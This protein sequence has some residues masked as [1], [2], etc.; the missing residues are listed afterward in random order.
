MEWPDPDTRI[1]VEEAGRLGVQV[2]VSSQVLEIGER[3]RLDHPVLAVELFDGSQALGGDRDTGV[4]ADLRHGL[5][6]HLGVARAHAHVGHGQAP[7]SGSCERADVVAP[8]PGPPSGR[9]ELR[10][11]TA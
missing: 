1:L 4:A 3:T 10:R 11:E 9:E 8:S 6:G 2:Q 5:G 7:P